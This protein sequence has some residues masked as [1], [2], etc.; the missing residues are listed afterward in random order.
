[1]RPG[2]RLALARG[3]AGWRCRFDGLNHPRFPTI[4]SSGVPHMGFLSLWTRLRRCTPSSPQASVH[5][6]RLVLES[7]EDRV[8][9]TTFYVDTVA[10]AADAAAFGTAPDHPFRSIQYAVNQAA[11]AGDTVE[12][13]GGTY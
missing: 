5:R 13:A 4:Y 2:E 6:P 12:V 10:G 8:V 3:Q 7:L 9:P 1:M 11:A